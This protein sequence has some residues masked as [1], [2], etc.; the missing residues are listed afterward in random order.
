MVV[1][2]SCVFVQC[3]NIINDTL[4]LLWLHRRKFQKAR[5]GIILLQAI[6]RMRHQ[7]QVFLRVS[8]VWH[9]HICI[10]FHFG[11]VFIYIF[12]E[13]QNFRKREHFLKIIRSTWNKSTWLRNRWLYIIILILPQQ[14]TACGSMWAFML[15]WFWTPVNNWT[16]FNACERKSCIAYVLS[17][18][19]SYG[20]S[21]FNLFVVVSVVSIEGPWNINLS[22]SHVLI[23]LRQIVGFSPLQHLNC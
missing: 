22:W 16:S 19:H 4:L 11:F 9:T 10:L 14:K 17:L 2:S 23:R 15:K 7:R 21:S 3:N 20:H 12:L 13:L 18:V 6:Y 8:L 1:I 5:K